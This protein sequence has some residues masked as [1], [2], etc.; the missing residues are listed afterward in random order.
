MGSSNGNNGTFLVIV[1]MLDSVEVKLDSSIVI[2]IFNTVRLNKFRIVRDVI[3]RILE[4]RQVI[5]D[6][7]ICL[8]GQSG[9]EG[10]VRQGS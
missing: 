6:D 10:V 2:I 8:V 3:I 4:K 9:K 7:L 5:F 1:K